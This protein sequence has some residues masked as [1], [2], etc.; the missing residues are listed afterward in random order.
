MAKTNNKVVAVDVQAE[1]DKRVVETL[2]E[3]IQSASG[4]NIKT[5][6]KVFKLPNGVE[7][8]GPL[9][10]VILDFVSQNA[11]YE[12]G[13][14]DGSVVPPDCIAVG[15]N[16]RTLIPSD[17]SLKKQAESCAICPNNEFGSKG[18]GKACANNRLL[19]VVEA[20][21]NPKAPIYL[22]KVS[23]TALKSFDGYVASVHAQ[24]KSLPVK[25]ITEISFDPNLRYPSLRFGNPEPNPNWEMHFKRIDEAHAR[26]VQIP[27][28]VAPVETK[29][30]SKGK[31]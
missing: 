17:K 30:K 19:A 16:P 1:M 24:F 18:K 28:M 26:L 20:N 13:W 9:A 8:P 12:G 14:V 2:R 5:Q 15:D 3:R 6:D 25:V 21:D 29:P 4:D 10:V 27:D 11:F 31:K 23:P 7:S 22:L